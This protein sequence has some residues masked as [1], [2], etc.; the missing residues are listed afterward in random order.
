MAA[1]FA[2]VGMDSRDN[3]SEDV[4][5]SYI[6]TYIFIFS[7]VSQKNKSSEK[8]E[9]LTAKS[10]KCQTILRCAPGFTVPH[11]ESGV[12]PLQTPLRS[13]VLESGVAL[14]SLSLPLSEPW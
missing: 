4:L 2:R 10:D 11:R 9:L 13:G 6:Y 3:H 12:S 7:A 8:I 1:T 14:V 5:V